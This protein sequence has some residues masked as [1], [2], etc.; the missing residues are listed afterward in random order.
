MII[1]SKRVFISGQ[2][3][4]AQILIDS[5]KIQ[6]VFPYDH[7][8]VDVD[9]G[10]LM[11]VPGFIDLHTHGA[12]GYAVDE[13]T[14]DGLANWLAKLPEEGVTSFLPTTATNYKE[15]TIK[16]L[17]NITAVYEKRPRGAQ[18]IGA[19]LEGPFL[20]YTFRG[21]H[22]PDLLR[23]PSL[24]DFE[25]FQQAAGGK[26]RYMTLA[27][28]HDADFALTRY[29]SRNGVVV[30]LGHSGASLEMA[31]L[32]VANGASSFTHSYNGMKGLHHREP[33]VVG[34]LMTSDAYAEIIADGYHVHPNAINIL[35]KA[36]NYSRIILITDSL[37]AKG[38]PKGTYE[39]GL[40]SEKIEID[41]NGTAYLSGTNTIAGSSLRMNLAVKFLVQRA[42]IS[43]E[44]A[45]LAASFYPAQVLGL[46][47]RKG[48]ILVGN[49]ADLTVL[50]DG[51]NVQQTYCLG[52]RM[53][54]EGF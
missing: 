21:A 32:A 35:F 9:Y 36:K 45:L 10:D 39:F 6:A 13:G 42:M 7:E 49:D 28:E 11:V 31:L 24:A 19:H 8:K 41:D 53:L 16:A 44:H 18:I 5:Q 46:E 29:A 14:P 15:A 26:I 34:A 23:T 27:C 12:Y 20:D 4:K 25:D 38:L 51:W 48:Q 1:Q 43:V 3:M 40:G 22:E 52:E 30:S 50:D 54:K 2:F 37:V 33:G 47:K 17:Q